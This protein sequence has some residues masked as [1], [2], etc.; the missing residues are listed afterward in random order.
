[1]DS[2]RLNPQPFA[3]I[4]GEVYENAGGG[5]YLCE[6]REGSARCAWFTNVASGWTCLAK[7]IV[8]YEDGTIEW[9]RSTDGHFVTMD[10]YRVFLCDPVS[11]DSKGEV[12]VWAGSEREAMWKAEDKNPGTMAA[13]ADP[14]GASARV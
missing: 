9:D 12:T 14:T 1:M 4:C 6:S 2:K 5:R 10:E 11:G 8:R 13:A 3:P 7:G